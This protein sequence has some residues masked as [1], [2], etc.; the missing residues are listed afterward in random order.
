MSN[1]ARQST[2]IASVAAIWVVVDSGDLPSAVLFS[3]AVHMERMSA[4]RMATPGTAYYGPHSK[5]SDRSVQIDPS[6]LRGVHIK[7]KQGFQRCIEGDL[8]SAVAQGN[9]LNGSVWLTSQLQNAFQFCG[10]L[11]TQHAIAIPRCIRNVGKRSYGTWRPKDQQMAPIGWLVASICRIAALPAAHSAS[12]HWRLRR[13]TDRG[14]VPSL[15]H[16]N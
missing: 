9:G 4:S 14:S 3:P 1:R 13:F 7:G 8:A 2:D 11:R 12:R 15:N 10:V 16:Q 6:R 5:A